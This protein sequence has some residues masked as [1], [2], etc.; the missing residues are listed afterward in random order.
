LLDALKN[1]TSDRHRFRV[2][3]SV[4]PEALAILVAE[5]ASQAPLIDRWRAF[6]RFTLPLRGNDLEVP[7]GPHIAKA[8]ERTREAVF[9][10]EI[11]PEDARAYAR[12][13]ARK[14]LEE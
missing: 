1:A 6:Q 12:D 2:C 11:T 7:A 5:N 14:Y 4:S 10:G 8:L 13:L 9:N 3:K